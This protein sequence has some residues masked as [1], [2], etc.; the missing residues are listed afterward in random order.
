MALAPRKAL[1]IADLPDSFVT[2][3][4]LAGME[5]P[6]D[7]IFSNGPF[8][9]EDLERFADSFD[10]GI[11]TPARPA[12]PELVRPT[13]DE[14][15][16]KPSTEEFARMTGMEEI[17]AQRFFANFLMLVEEN[18][19]EAVAKCFRYPI[20]VT[21]EDGGV[22]VE[23]AE[24]FQPYYDLIF[25]ESLWESVMVNRYDQERSDLIAGRGMV[26]AAGGAIWFAEMGEGQ[27]FILI[28][29]NSEGRSV[30]QGEA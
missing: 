14:V 8:A 6:V 7:D 22:T 12:K 27:A 1:I 3:N 23:T 2:V 15:L 29:H 16:G 5:T 24:E 26:A 30:V 17:E 19:R 13:L 25:T 20:T 28:I 21:T 18:D 9:A 11:L 4:V 10:F